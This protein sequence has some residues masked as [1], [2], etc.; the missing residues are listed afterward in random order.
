MPSFKASTGRIPPLL[1]PLARLRLLLPAAPVYL[2]DTNRAVLSLV[3][4][5]FC[6]K[7]EPYAAAQEDTVHLRVQGQG[8]RISS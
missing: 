4:G 2:L 5:P 3:F 6:W 1:L 8:L 7:A